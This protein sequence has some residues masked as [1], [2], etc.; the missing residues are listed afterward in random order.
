MKR[1]RLYS[2]LV[3]LF[4]VLSSISCF[5]SLEPTMYKSNQD[6]PGDV[7]PSPEVATAIIIAPHKTVTLEEGK[8]IL[9]AAKEALALELKKRGYVATNIYSEVLPDI[10]LL[11]IG[12]Q[13]EQIIAET[14]TKGLNGV[15]IF[16]MTPKR[17]KPTVTGDL[18]PEGAPQLPQ[19]KVKATI[20][21]DPVINGHCSIRVYS[22]QGEWLKINLGYCK[23]YV[24]TTELTIEYFADTNRT[25][26]KNVVGVKG[27]AYHYREIGI[28]EATVSGVQSCFSGLYGNIQNYLKR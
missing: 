12:K 15:F 16:H 18:Y 21:N 1:A 3:C 27:H 11:G 23:G 17:D 8:L 24:E 7:F 6:F 10:Y 9:S 13:K 4:L 19:Y 2:L 26:I 28:D 5:Y 20:V 25:T 22:A 14:L